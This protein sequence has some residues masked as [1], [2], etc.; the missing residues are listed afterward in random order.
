MSKVAMSHQF[1]YSVVLYLEILGFIWFDCFCAQF[2]RKKG[3]ACSIEL[4]PLT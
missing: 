4:Q 1:L 2:G 3:K